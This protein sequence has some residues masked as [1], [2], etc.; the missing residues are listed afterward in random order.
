M[1]TTVTALASP[2]GRLGQRHPQQQQAAIAAL[3][4]AQRALHALQKA[5]AEETSSLD[6]GPGAAGAPD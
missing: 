5:V 6:G 1:A 3:R 4:G 2:A